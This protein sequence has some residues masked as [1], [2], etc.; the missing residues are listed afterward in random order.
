MHELS[1]YQASLS[2]P[3]HFPLSYFLFVSLLSHHLFCLSLR[4][5]S[6]GLYFI[7]SSASHLIST[8][9]LIF[10]HYLEKSALTYSLG[11]SLKSAWCRLSCHPWAF[12]RARVDSAY[13]IIF[14]A[15]SARKYDP[16]HF[17]YT[18]VQIRKL[19]KHNNV[20][21]TTSKQRHKRRRTSCS[22]ANSS[23]TSPM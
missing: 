21:G 14:L 7:I 2:L 8:L 10:S 23:T 5:L 1:S 22:C 18:Y 11:M 15:Y 3:R 12:P 6:M 16:F 17:F 19:R 9:V 20:C 13:L 4:S